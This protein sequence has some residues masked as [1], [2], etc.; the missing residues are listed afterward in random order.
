MSTKESAAIYIKNTTDGTAV[1]RLIHKNSPATYGMQSG[2]WTAKPGQT[3]GPLVVYF[4]VGFDSFDVLDLWSVYLSVIDGS[5]P[6]EY[7]N[8]GTPVFPHWKECQL[9]HGDAGQTIT[10]T[11]SSTKFDIPLKSGGCSDSMTYVGRYSAVSRVFVLMLENHSFDNV[12]AMSGIPGITAATTSDSNIYAGKTYAVQRGAPAGMPT[13]PGHEFLDVVEQLGGPGATYAAGG[14]YPA[15][16]N[17]GFA[18][19]YATTKSEGNPPQPADVGKILECFDTPKQL[20]VIYQLATE[21]AV[22]DHW[23]SSLPGPT[24]PNRF[25]VHGASSAGLD[26]SPTTG[27]MTTW[28]APGSGFAYP[29]G[30]IFDALN[31][32]H[33][34]WRLYN[35]D[36]DQFS[37]DPVSGLSLALGA[38][39]TVSALKGITLG[40]IGSFAQLAQDLQGPYPY[41]YTFIEPHYGDLLHGTYRGGSSQHPMDDLYGGEGLIKATYE[42]IRNS[43]HWNSSVLIITYDEH[44]GFYD[45][46]PPGAAPAPDDHSGDDYK[47]YGFT[48]QQYGV[49]VPAV[50]VSPLIPRGVV[51]HTIYDHASVPATLERLSGF[52]PL[53][54]R[55]AGANDVRHLF[56]L[57]SPRTDCPQTLAGPAPPSTVQKTAAA[58]NAHPAAEPLPQSGNLPGFLGILLKTQLEVSSG[59]PDEQAPIIDQFSKLKTWGDAEKY[60][61][62]MLEDIGR[63]RAQHARG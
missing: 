58:D 57:T 34:M 43:P 26:H 7:V 9:Q 24:W 20:P 37:H 29:N 40:D 22:C 54:R 28:E 45:S 51:D 27:E 31:S 25:F 50:V 63:L 33:C 42:A 16:N 30:S 19:N 4:P 60:A 44:G 62:A 13:D 15:V 46:V 18:A 17:S 3:T 47:R 10:L 14:A 56:S 49:R 8:S 1:V 12:F 6:G 21:F 55:D 59:S 38:I 35:D 53:T 39:P 41:R 5:K 11:V 61:A 36:T 23:F 52:G 2:E 32:A 48:F